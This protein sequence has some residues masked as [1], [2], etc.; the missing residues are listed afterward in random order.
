MRIGRVA[1]ATEP[2]NYELVS[3]IVVTCWGDVLSN[4]HLEIIGNIVVFRSGVSRHRF[5]LVR[6]RRLI[7]ACFFEAVALWDIL[8]SRVRR[9]GVDVPSL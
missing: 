5:S 9:H 2:P 8:I 4:A 6:R 1:S 7:V 3:I